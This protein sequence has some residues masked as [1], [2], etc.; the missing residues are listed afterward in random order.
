MHAD[1][2]DVDASLVRRLLGAQFPRWAV[3]PVEPVLPWGTDNAVYRLGEDLSVRLPRIAGAVGQVEVEHRWLPRLAPHL[4]LRLPTPVGRGAPAEDYPWEWSVH[5]WIKGESAAI[6][7]LADPC[8]AAADL[9][10]FVTA[11]QRIDTTGGP[12]AG[13]GVPLA[14]RDTV[15]REA[16]A[17]LAGMID[18]AA[19]TEAWEAALRA[20]VHDAPAVWIHGDLTPGNL[21]VE[22]GRLSAVID[23][24]ALGVGD[25]AC[26]L[27]VAWNL[28]SGEARDVF[29]SA[30]AADEATWRR[31][32]GWALS[33][34]LVALPY[35]LETNPVI[36]ESSWRVIDEV[37]H[38]R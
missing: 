23:F 26:D 32:R 27:I 5:D 29:R 20:P 12:A 25:P 9:A 37:L 7:R 21:L 13:R 2:A 1:E 18:T 3:L 28:F 4:P 17:A 16:I 34:A 38:G 33:I 6:D 15:T 10:G 35:Y 31:G 8:R 36:V 11:L 14:T 19:V 22:D 24:G 30:S